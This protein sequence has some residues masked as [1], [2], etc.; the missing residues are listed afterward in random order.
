[1]VWVDCDPQAGHK[2]VGRRPALI[3]S[4]QSYNQK[5]GLVLLCPITNQM[6]A[7]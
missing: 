7:C 4:P 6:Q 1:M 3:A 5:V 2:Q